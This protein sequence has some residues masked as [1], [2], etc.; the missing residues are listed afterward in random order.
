MPILGFTLI[1]ENLR[2][3]RIENDLLVTQD[4]QITKNFSL[5]E[6]T[7]ILLKSEKLKMD[8]TTHRSGRNRRINA[9]WTNHY[10]FIHVLLL[11]WISI[12][13]PG[14]AKNDKVIQKSDYQLFYFL[15]F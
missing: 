8:N 3:N 6:E 1:E 2:S 11:Q 10:F 15:Q 9:L 12:N 14:L 4:K 5:L 7:L 13:I